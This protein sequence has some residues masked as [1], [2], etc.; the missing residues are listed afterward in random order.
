MVAAQ[1][2]KQKTVRVVVL[3]QDNEEA[4]WKQLAAG[5]F[6][7]GYSEADAVYDSI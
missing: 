6:L 3:L 5:Q 4:D 1:I 7:A 2:P